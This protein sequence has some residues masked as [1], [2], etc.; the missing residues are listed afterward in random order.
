[1]RTLLLTNETPRPLDRRRE[2]YLLRL[3]AMSLGAALVVAHLNMSLIGISPVDGLSPLEWVVRAALWM[4]PVG[5]LMVHS[6][7]VIRALAEPSTV[8]RTR[9]LLWAA[10]VCPLADL[11][12]FALLDTAVFLA[13][14]AL[15]AWYVTRVGWDR[16]LRVAAVTAGA[17]TLVNLAV[18]LAGVPEAISDTATGT[19]RLAGILTHPNQAGQVAGIALL[20]AWHSHSRGSTWFARGLAAIGGVALLWSQSRTSVAAVA[21]AFGWIA[22]HRSSRSKRVIGFLLGVVILG[23]VVYA[24]TDAVVSQL[25]RTGSTTEI[26]TL[27]GRTQLWATVMRLASEQPLTGY[28]LGNERITDAS[29]A[30][31]VPWDANSAHSDWLNTYLAFGLPGLGLWIAMWISYVRRTTDNPDVVRDAFVVFA[32]VLGLTEV[33]IGPVFPSFVYY[34]LIGSLAAV[35]TRPRPTSSPLAVGGPGA[36]IIHR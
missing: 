6:N 30:G 34:M 19:N 16:F 36:T 27:T 14:A 1:M 10:A 12:L 20:C 9:T 35:Y 13:A 3:S 7:G 23:A 18:A 15:P 11:P 28:G 33:A 31:D 8:W 24:G 5:M 4:G 17:I 22:L 2:R 26:V 21:L 32:F 25:S 29:T